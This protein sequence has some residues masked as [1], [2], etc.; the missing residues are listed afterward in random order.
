MKIRLVSIA[1]GSGTRLWPISRSALP[2]QF[3]KLSSD[4]TMLQQ[5]VQRTKGLD[6]NAISVICNEEHRFFVAD[7]LKNEENLESIIYKIKTNIQL[8]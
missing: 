3:L 1:G 8:S 5:T 6:I 4:I 2:K 7:Q